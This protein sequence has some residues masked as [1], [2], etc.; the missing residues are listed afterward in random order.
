[1]AYPQDARP[2]LVEFNDGMEWQDITAYVLQNRGINISVGQSGQANT[3]GPSSLNFTLDNRD[4]RFTVGNPTSPYGGTFRPGAGIRWSIED[5]GTTYV[6]F[7]G[8]LVTAT[9]NLEVTTQ[10]NTVQVRA[11]SYFTRW[12]KPLETPSPLLSAIPSDPTLVDYWP[13]EDEG[14]AIQTLAS[15]LPDGIPA[16]I[17]ASVDAAS[18]S[19]FYGSRPIVDLGTGQITATVRRYIPNGPTWFHWLARGPVAAVDTTIL[20]VNFRG[21]S[22]ARIGLLA[23]TT[24]DLRLRFYDTDQAIITTSAYAGTFNINDRDVLL[25]VRVEQVGANVAYEI[26]QVDQLDP[27]TVVSTSGSV[28]TQTVNAASNVTF[29]LF[30]NQDGPVGHLGVFNGT[31]D[32]PT[33]RQAFGAF[34]GE[35]AADR[36]IRLC[37]QN[38]IPCR[39]IGDYLITEE[40]GPQPIDTLGN[41]IQEC[42]TVEHSFLFETREEMGLTFITRDALYNQS[43][44]TRLAP[45]FE[46]VATAVL[47]Y[48]LRLDPDDAAHWFPGVQFRLHKVSDDSLVESTLFTVY[49]TKETYSPTEIGILFTPPAAALPATTSKAVIYRDAQFDVDYTALQRGSSYEDGGRNITNRVDLARRGG[50]SVTVEDT[51]TALSIYEPPVGAGLSER[52][53]TLGLYQDSQLRAHADWLLALGINPD[54]RWL[55]MALA[56]HHVSMVGRQADILAV[57]IG[58]KVAMSGTDSLFLFDEQR[59]LCTGYDEVFDGNRLHTITAHGVPENPYHVAVFDDP[60]HRWAAQSS[61]LAQALTSTQ[62]GSV[63]VAVGDAPWTTAS[64]DFP[65][66]IMVGGERM[67]V[68]GISGTPGTPVLVGT[69]TSASGDNTSLSPGLPSGATSGDVVLIVAAIRDLNATVDV[70]ANWTD[71]TPTAT[72]LKVLARTYN[73]VWT[74]PSVSFTGGFSGTT[75]TAMSAAFR[76]VVAVDLGG[77]AQL[78][79]ADGGQDVAVRTQGM[80]KLVGQR[81]LRL[82]VGHKWDD[83]TSVAVVPSSD[84]VTVASVSTTSGNDAAMTWAYTVDEVSG[85]FPA[86]FDLWDVTG[87]AVATFSSQVLFLPA[88]TQTFTVSTRSVNGVV[89][90]HTTG[91][92]VDIA[93]PQHYAL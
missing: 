45:D 87:G 9:A 33:L 44:D 17:K 24:G 31:P 10:A 18:Y 28:S 60:D 59:Q 62:T 49:A 66:D 89:K 50:S 22:I 52:A 29:G 3:I 25:G 81:G 68:S 34:S 69:G 41:Q 42:G 88:T 56:P 7:S 5:T 38:D 27:T 76:N 12:E 14:D 83:W 15:A 78:F 74:M 92:S 21:S 37:A 93:E 36:F 35:R 57:N 73:G 46:I 23:T 70:P 19:G 82:A 63:S 85:D 79:D 20:S 4:G 48:Q 58:H 13:M 55:N 30:N 51:E 8:E 84:L 75:T 1:M 91:T 65:Q 6:R 53:E 40:M 80:G 32:Q 61:T 72:R 2:F 11:G 90:A 67:T 86:R 77:N 26:S 47:N 16:I 71:L 43:S 64:G 54:P 39:L